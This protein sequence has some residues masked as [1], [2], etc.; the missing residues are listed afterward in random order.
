[1]SCFEIPVSVPSKSINPRDPQRLEHPDGDT[2]RE[3]HGLELSLRQPSTPI[4]QI[5][6]SPRTEPA[7]E[8]PEDRSSIPGDLHKHEG[9]GAV[10]DDPLVIASNTGPKRNK[11]RQ[12]EID[13]AQAK[14]ATSMLSLG[15]NQAAREKI[16]LAMIKSHELSR[17]SA[18]GP[19][20]N[21]KKGELTE[22]PPNTPPLKATHIP[23]DSTGTRVRIGSVHSSDYDMD[24]KD[25]ETREDA[26]RE[27]HKP[28]RKTHK[29]QRFRRRKK[30]Y[31]PEDEE[32]PASGRG[33]GGGHARHIPTY[34]KWLSQ[35]DIFVGYWATPWQPTDSVHMSK[36]GTPATLEALT[37]LL[38]TRNLQ[39]VSESNEVAKIC[40]SALDGGRSTWPVYA[41]NAR[42]GVV[43]EEDD[44]TFEYPGLM[45]NLPAVK[46]LKDYHWQTES[47]AK[48]TL[49]EWQL[50]DLMMLDTWLSI[51]G[52]EPEILDGDSDLIHNTPLLIQFLFEVFENRFRK[53][54]RSANEGVSL[55]APGAGCEYGNL[56]ERVAISPASQRVH[57]AFSRSHL[58]NLSTLNAPPSRYLTN[59]RSGELG[60]PYFSPFSMDF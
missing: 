22:S 54:D 47:Y 30:T 46:L 1:M 33:P 21:L 29:P 48:T 27:D 59:L 41:I 16:E 5:Y 57:W 53:F 6:D 2:T 25:Q 12:H 60:W 4:S 51:C 58:P 32:S 14:D 11:T 44:A 7:D 36:G 50:A 18:T 20:G 10:S 9:K 40:E 23:S 15:P 38:A 31:D 26:R 13:F 37:G 39:Y 3:A 34:W 24:A 52:R 49:I 28:Q 8:K 43:V 17:S 42:G 55:P 45:S 35:M 19:D 56:H